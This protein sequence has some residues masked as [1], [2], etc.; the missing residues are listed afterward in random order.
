MAD[1]PE[2]GGSG[3]P[4]IEL[5]RLGPRASHMHERILFGVKSDFSLGLCLSGYLYILPVLCFPGNFHTVQGH[6]S[7]SVSRTFKVFG[8]SIR[9]IVHS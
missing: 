8:C 5:D 4:R 9:P 2:K 6:P 1:A 7:A 3:S